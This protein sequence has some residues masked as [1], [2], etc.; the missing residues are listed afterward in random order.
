MLKYRVSEGWGH[1]KLDAVITR[2]TV[3]NQFLSLSQK[4]V[5][6]MVVLDLNFIKSSHM[7]LVYAFE[8][9]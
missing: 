9:L 6:F 4:C 8:D 3:H 5:Y 1:L 7:N 2:L